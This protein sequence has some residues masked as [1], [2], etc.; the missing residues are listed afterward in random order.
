[1]K[2]H[3]KCP[4]VQRNKPYLWSNKQE[5]GGYYNFVQHAKKVSP[6]V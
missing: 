6:H 4:Q 3:T 2:N 1:M 5:S